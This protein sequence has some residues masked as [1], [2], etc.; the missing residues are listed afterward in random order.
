MNNRPIEN[1]PFTP[2]LPQGTRVILCGT[3]PP[4]QDKW[5]MDF[6]YPNFYNDMWRIFGLIFYNDKDKFFDKKNKTV[7]KAAIQRMLERIRVGIGET[8]TKAIRTKD[9]ASDKFLEIVK[10]VDLPELFAKIPECHDF[11]T[12]GEKAASVI[13]GLTST[14]IPKVGH[15]LDCEIEMGNGNIRKF[16]HW[17]MPS[18]SRA[19]PMK[20]EDKTRYYREMFETTGVLLTP[21]SEI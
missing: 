2:F 4:K 3:F 12:T 9:N 11:V 15:Y 18:T 1:H 20:L 7:D 19:Y 14:E 5:S 13:A 21:E 16:R 8:V 6:F 17:R 10:R